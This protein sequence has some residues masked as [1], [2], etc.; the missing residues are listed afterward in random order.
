MNYNNN[1]NNI[2]MKFKCVMFKV[3]IVVWKYRG[4]DLRVVNIN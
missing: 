4:K 2:L 1:S 3:I